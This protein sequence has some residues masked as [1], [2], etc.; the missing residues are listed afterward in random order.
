MQIDELGPQSPG[1]ARAPVER[2]D[3]LVLFGATGD[4]ARK[5]LFS[6]IYHM[7]ESGTLDMPVVGVA[8]S[9]WDSERFR[10]HVA[11]AIG[12]TVQGIDPAVL[13]ALLGRTHLV[14]GDYSDEVTFAQSWRAWGRRARR[15]TSRSRRGCSRR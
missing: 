5:K 2:A 3:A 11:T 1:M 8:R 14:G 15:S 6:A 7:A 13:E 4:L 9:G 12:E 10:A